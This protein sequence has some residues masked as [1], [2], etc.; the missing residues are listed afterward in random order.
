MLANFRDAGVDIDHVVFQLEVPLE[1]SPAALR[2]A[3]EEGVT[4]IFK[5]SAGTRGLAGGG[6]RAERRALPERARD[7]AARRP[8]ASR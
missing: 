1:T 8:V 4:T 6:L 3:R 7:R 2:V 5:P